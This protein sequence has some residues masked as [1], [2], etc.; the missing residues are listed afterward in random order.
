[1]IGLQVASRQLLHLSSVLTPQI[2]IPRTGRLVASTVSQYVVWLLAPSSLV[3]PPD[4]G[5]E[6]NT[7][8]RIATG[9]AKAKV[10]KGWT[11]LSL[12]FGLL[13]MFAILECEPDGC[14]QVALFS[15]LCFGSNLGFELLEIR[16]QYRK[17]SPLR[18][19]FF[20]HY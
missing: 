20:D 16:S 4:L 1:M 7:N 17:N 3:F 2:S 14:L 11:Y 8:R 13:L 19:Y 10:A 9:L 12:G 5:K 18:G 15:L 6:G